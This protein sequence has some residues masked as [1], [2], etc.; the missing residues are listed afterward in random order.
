MN[1]YLPTGITDVSISVEDIN[2][3]ML[4]QVN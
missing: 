1:E 4:E 2:D 3:M